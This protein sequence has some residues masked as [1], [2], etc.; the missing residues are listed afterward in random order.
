M[1][2]RFDPRRR[3]A[4]EPVARKTSNAA[5]SGFDDVEL[6]DVVAALHFDLAEWLGSDAPLKVFDRISGALDDQFTSVVTTGQAVDRETFL[7]GMWSARN[8][9]AGV[10]IE[11]SEVQEIARSGQLIVVRFVA[12]NRIGTVKTG[13]RTVTAVLVTDGRTYLWRTVHETPVPEPAA[14]TPQPATESSAVDASGDVA[15]G[16]DQQ[17]GGGGEAAGIAEGLGELGTGEQHVA[18]A[19]QVEGGAAVGEPGVGEAVADLSGR[20]VAAIG[21][22]AG[23]PASGAEQQL[24]VDPVAPARTG[25]LG[26]DVDDLAGELAALGS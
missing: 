3:R 16:P 11:V 23:V 12:E 8:M 14:A 24:V 13:R 18:G 7:A 1:R 20:K 25:V 6:G 17:T 10:E 19:E 2:G 9:L 4:E 21:E 5:G 15:V 26:G 22:G